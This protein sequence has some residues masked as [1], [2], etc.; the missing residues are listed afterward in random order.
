MVGF[1]LG[2]K[3]SSLSL[4]M[5]HFCDISQGEFLVATRVISGFNVVDDCLNCS[6]FFLHF[7]VVASALVGGAS[8]NNLRHQF[9]IFAETIPA[10]KLL[11]VKGDENGVFKFFLFSPVALFFIL[12]KHQQG[13]FVDQKR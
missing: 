1:L 12:R 9:E 11:F 2:L 10:G 7:L 13:T 8:F 4:Y 5:I 3:R 6:S